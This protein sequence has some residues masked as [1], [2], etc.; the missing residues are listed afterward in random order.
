MKHFLVI[1]GLTALVWLG[2][3][4][5]ETDEYPM[6]VRIEM[7]GYDTVRYA[8]VQA[9]TALDLQVRISGFNAL[10]NSIRPHEHRVKVMLSEGQEAVAVHSIDE[11]LRES[12]LG[13]KQVSSEKDTLR[14]LLSERSH[15]DYHARIDRVN[16]S[17]VEQYGLYG[18]PVVTPSTVVLYGPTEVLDSIHEVR[19][20]PTELYN[21]KSTGTFRIPLEP[22]WEQYADVH[23]SCKEVEVYLPV[24]P[25]VEKVYNV[26]ITVEN[27]DSTVDLRLYPQQAKVRVWVAQRDITHEP[28]FTVS[29]NYRDALDNEG[30]VVPHLAQF[31]SYVRLRNVEPQEVQCVVIK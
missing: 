11:Q 22:V 17:F 10:L 29:I 8:V 14:I 28:N 3:S 27:A 7:T 6:R 12:I 9:D 21:I 25:Y 18:E 23:P 15:R 4:M 1:L 20:M 26:P 24:E 13:A 2:V 30:R 19:A 16:F 5:S 31:P